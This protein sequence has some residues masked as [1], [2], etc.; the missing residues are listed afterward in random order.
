LD[1]A[2]AE[3]AAFD[4]KQAMAQL[5]AYGRLEWMVGNADW[6]ACFDAALG[7]HGVVYHVVV[8]CESGGFT[9]T[10]EAGEV[11]LRDALTKLAG[12]PYAYACLCADACDGDSLPS[13]EDV[14]ACV[15]SWRAH[16]ETL[17][18]EADAA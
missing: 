11:P 16:L 6:V 4:L 1:T 13:N 5:D 3:A 7:P 9:Q 2:Y 8:D 15:A 17:I 10:Q 18:E 14:E 12:L